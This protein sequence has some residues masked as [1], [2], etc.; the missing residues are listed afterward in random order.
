M[1]A[2]N[3]FLLL[4]SLIQKIAC[5]NDKNDFKEDYFYIGIDKILG[6]K[7]ERNFIESLAYFKQLSEEGNAYSSYILG[8]LYQNDKNIEKDFAKSLFYF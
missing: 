3:C 1:M 8:M 4:L 7:K 6:N 2:F 5:D